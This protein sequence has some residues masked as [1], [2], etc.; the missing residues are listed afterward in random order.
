MSRLKKDKPNIIRI[1]RA[2]CKKVLWDAC[3]VWLESLSKEEFENIITNNWIH[4]KAPDIESI[5]QS[6]PHKVLALYLNIMYK[7]EFTS[8]Y[9]RTVSGSLIGHNNHANYKVF[10]DR[11]ISRDAK[12]FL[13]FKLKFAPHILTTKDFIRKNNEYRF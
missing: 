6:K 5:R 2:S 3:L 8:A 4:L 9:R 1:R 10:V 11:Y 13:L 12:L 7:L